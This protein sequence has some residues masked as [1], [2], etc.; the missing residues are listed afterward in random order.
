M[1]KTRTTRRAVALMAAAAIGTSLLAGCASDDD[2]GDKAGGTDSKG[3][4][5]ITVGLFG[6]FGFQE[7]GLY[8]EYEKLNPKVKIEQSVV[9]RNENYYPQL[10]TRLASNSGLADIQGIEVANIAEVVQTQADKFADL[11]KAGGVSKDDYFD[12]KW[13][14]ATTADGKTIGLG[15]DIGPMAI[16]YRKDHFKA[17]GLPTDR[18]EVGKLWEGDWQKYLD[19]GKKFMD[20]A[21]KGVKWVDSASGLYNAA[22]SSSATRYYDEQGEVVYKTNPDV[23]EAWDVAA[24]AASEDMTDKHELFTDSW[25]KAMNNG[26][27]ATLSCPAWMLGYIQD[28]GGD[29]AEG[30]WDVAPAPKAGNWGGSF[31][32]VPESS[33][34]KEEAIKLAAWL[35]AP[36]QQA[37]LFAERGSFPSAPKS[38]ETPEVAEATHEYFSDAP[39][40]E[41]FSK[42]AE[43]I[44]TQV[45]GPK[46]QVIQENITR[47]GLLQMERSGLSSDKAWEE[48]TKAVDNALDE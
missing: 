28:K 37:K 26:T 48:A 40:G 1:R 2:S 45:I 17:A 41:I 23:K 43:G 14:Q 27:F 34:N 33:K 6:T 25:N 36:T 38:Y 15:T 4:T 5:V 11:S 9:E 22:I 8:E 42:A 47:S 7:A 31:L 35:T 10:L 3:K 16:C 21:P 24:E 19:T 32:G 20:S 44:P 46:D 18:D 30:K 12:W 39:I 29:K 13:N